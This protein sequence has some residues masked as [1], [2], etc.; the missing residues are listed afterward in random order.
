MRRR[1]LLA[2][3]AASVGLSGCVENDAEGALVS[4]NEAMDRESTVKGASREPASTLDV[5]GSVH[6]RAHRLGDDLDLIE[7]SGTEWLHAFLDVRRKYDD[8]VDPWEDSDV[9]TLRRASRETSVDLLL[10]L[11]WNFIGIFGDLEAERVPSA[12]SERERGLIEYA[13]RLLEAIGEPVDVVV[14]GNEPVWE[15][16]DEDILGGNAP[17]V[18]FTRRLKDHLVDR[19]TVGDPQFLVGA[20]NRLYDTVWDDYERFFRQLFDVAREDDVDG[21]DLHVHYYSLSQA[22][23]MLEVARREFPESTMTVTEF[24]PVFRYFDHVDTPLAEFEGGDRFARRWGVEADETVTEYLEA[25]KDDRLSSREAADFYGTMPWYNVHFVED[26]YDLLAEFDVEVG[27][28]GFLVEEDVHN[29]VW[30]EDWSPFP[31]N[32]LFQPALIDSEHGAHPYYLE[33]FRRLA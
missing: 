3:G 26:M 4:L 12:G 31:I 29:V 13:R 27:T 20:F 6:G 9:A 22:R 7:R 14:L 25:A 16:M 23:R 2:L 24:S 10:T 33:D 19:Y 11:Q 30:D 15:T 1:R 28:F 32:C 5:G 8:G 18:R 21:I 17:I